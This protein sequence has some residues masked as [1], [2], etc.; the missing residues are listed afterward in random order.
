MLNCCAGSPSFKS[1]KAILKTF[2]FAYNSGDDNLLRSC[3]SI[4]YITEKIAKEKLD[5]NGNPYYTKVE[6]L[7]FEILNINRGRIGIQREYSDQEILADVRFYSD[8]DPLYERKV[9]IFMSQKK[10][11]TS[12][13]SRWMI[14]RIPE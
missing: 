11:S 3:G 13:P 12:A 7:R 6:E 5:S 2:C 9:K 14:H 10:S 4:D 8:I 1:P